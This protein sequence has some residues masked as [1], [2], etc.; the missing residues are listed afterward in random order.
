MVENNPTVTRAARIA[1]ID[2]DDTLWDF[3]AN[4]R[5]ALAKLYELYALYR[6]WPTA[7][8]WIENYQRHNH[9]LWDLYNHARISKKYLMQ[10]RFRR[11]LVEI[12]A[13]QAHELGDRFDYEYLDLLADCTQLVDG[14]ID[15]LKRFRDAGW[16]TGIL[17]NGFTEV[18][19][20]KIRNSGLGPY[21]DYIVLSDDIGVNKPD[22]RIYR[23]A[24]SVAGVTADACLMI[25]DNP[26]TDIAGALAAGWQAIYFAPEGSNPATLPCPTVTT[27][28]TIMNT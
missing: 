24:E 20:R 13:P 21:I 3:K 4:S 2:L 12:G 26:D 9:H 17:S 22:V 14:A 5:I 19:H 16:K 10:Q 11:P 23:H 7:E 18:Q 27:L 8:A 25:G 1:W 15:L 28:A 6:F